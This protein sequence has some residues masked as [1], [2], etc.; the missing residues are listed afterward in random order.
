MFHYFFQIDSFGNGHRL[1]IISHSIPQGAFWA[2]LGEQKL[3]N[4][5][6]RPNGWT[7][8]HQIWYTSVDLSGNGHMLKTIISPSIEPRVEF[9]GV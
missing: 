3:K 9:W 5:E 7:D 2:V 1:K 4:L 6:N 8:W